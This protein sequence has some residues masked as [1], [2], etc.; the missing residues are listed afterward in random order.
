MIVFDLFVIV[1]NPILGIGISLYQDL[2][3]HD[4]NYLLRHWSTSRTYEL[5]TMYFNVVVYYCRVDAILSFA[6]TFPNM[7]PIR[8][9][10]A[11]ASGGWNMPAAKRSIN[12]TTDGTDTME[13]ETEDDSLEDSDTNVSGDLQPMTLVSPIQCWMMPLVD[14]SIAK[15]YHLQQWRQTCTDHQPW[16]QPVLDTTSISLSTCYHQCKDM[17][18]KGRGASC[19]HYDG[20]LNEKYSRSDQ[21]ARKWKRFHSSKVFLTTVQMV[22][23]TVKQS[24]D[25]TLHVPSLL[26]PSP[27]AVW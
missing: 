7:V 11:K 8:C 19:Q 27:F 21:E 12:F 10:S 20:Q 13:T 14:S 16:L 25:C 1:L 23:V 17:S 5:C 6:T 22:N 26:F 2:L 24:G 3:P 4:C 18:T 15:E 9:R